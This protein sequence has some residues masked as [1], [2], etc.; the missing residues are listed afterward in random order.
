MAARLHFL[1]KD[2]LD[3]LRSERIELGT[4][5]LLRVQELLRLLPADADDDALLLALAPLLARSPQEQALVYEKFR[6]CQKRADELF[7]KVPDT[8]QPPKPPSPFDKKI[9]TAKRWFWAAATAFAL[10]LGALTWI[11][12]RPDEKG[13]VEKSWAVTAGQTTTICP[14][15]LPELDTFGQKAIRFSMNAEFPHIKD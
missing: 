6:D 14:A 4:G 3:E 13:I 12:L 11:Y 5:A 10:L 1:V 8:P 9:S 2:L 15:D 7:G